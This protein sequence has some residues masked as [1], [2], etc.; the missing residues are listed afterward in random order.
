MSPLNSS[1]TETAQLQTSVL[2]LRSR[3]SACSGEQ[4]AGVMPP[5]LTSTFWP[6]RPACSPACTA[7][8]QTEV[9]DLHLAS[10]SHQDIAGLNIL[11]DQATL[12]NHVQ[13][14]GEL[15]GRFQFICS[16]RVSFPS[17]IQSVKVPPE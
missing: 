2:R 15:Q 7:P 1:R 4:Y 5:Q 8:H 13:A 16:R 10:G 11:M 6:A 12:V 9:G 17:A 3:P 14:P